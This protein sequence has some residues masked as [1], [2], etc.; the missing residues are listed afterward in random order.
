LPTNDADAIDELSRAAFDLLLKEPFYAHVFAGMPRQIN[1]HMT[2][3]GLCWDG[4]QISLHVNPEYLLKSVN[5]KHRVGILKQEIL[6]VCFRHLF[7]ESGRDRELFSIAADLVVTQL[8]KPWPLPDEYPALADFPD[9]QLSPDGTVEDYYVSL[10]ILFDQMLQAGY[11]QDDTHDI[12][13]SHSMPS[14]AVET[15]YP[16]SAKQLG[17]MLQD[18]GT[19][20]SDDGWAEAGAAVDQ[21]SVEGGWW[22]LGTGGG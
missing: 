16:K 22:L 4:Q 5:K 2:T 8:S 11:R 13:N 9:L 19:R 1:R 20:P 15:S 3:L 18:R 21:F 10:K 6:H 14:W 17:Q 7:R 12:E